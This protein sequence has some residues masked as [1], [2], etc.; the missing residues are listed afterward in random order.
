[1]T[2]AKRCRIA[3]VYAAPAG[4][5]GL[6][7][8]AATVIA[9]LARGGHEVFAVG[10][11]CIDAWPVTPIKHRVTWIEG[12]PRVPRSAVQYTPLR[13]Y[14]GAQV[15]LEHGLVARW[16][17]RQLDRIRPDLV[18]L[19]TQVALEGLY[20]CQRHGVP[21]I[22][23]N[24]N[25]G[26][27]NYR[28]VCEREWHKWCRGPFRDHPVPSVV[29]RVQQE[30]SL[31][32]HIRVSSTWA[33]ASTAREV[34]QGAKIVVVDQPLDLERF[35]SPPARP[36]SP[37]FQIVMVGSL[38]VRKGFLYLLRALRRIQWP[39]RLTLV[40]GT[41]S[42]EMKLALRRESAGLNVVLAPGDPI[43]AY[44]SS[45]ISILPSLEDGFGFVVAEGMACGLATIVTD[46]SGSAEWVREANAGWV[47]PAGRDVALA[48][49]LEEAYAKR[50]QL[51]DMGVRARQYVEQRASARCFDALETLVT[52]AIDGTLVGKQDSRGHLR[53]AP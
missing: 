2:T 3:V 24:P 45:D 26:I 1:M 11:G 33:A 16:A 51:A 38:D 18:Y 7:L 34:N 53:P 50:A 49:V 17:A 19:F 10:P 48:N 40:G 32:G 39:L 12:A 36:S 9:G 8:Q 23:D 20:W 15:W 13:V 42:R 22:V 27:A 4:L 37:T 14:P 43:P 35:R 25:G 52:S 46:Q 44:H 28:T 30:Y 41:G 5:G 21:S 29:E 47:V 31:A 6:G